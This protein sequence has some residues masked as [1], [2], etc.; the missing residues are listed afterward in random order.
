MGPVHLQRERHASTTWGCT[1]AHAITCDPEQV[2][3]VWSLPWSI[4]PAAGLVTIGER[5]RVAG[6]REAAP[7]EVLAFVLSLLP[8]KFVCILVK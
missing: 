6:W 5:V 8:R 7:Y 1:C 3:F 2:T 4:G